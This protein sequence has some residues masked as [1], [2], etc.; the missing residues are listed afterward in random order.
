V[1]MVMV[2]REVSRIGVNVELVNP[3]LGNVSDSRLIQKEESVY[4]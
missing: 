3:D 1:T 4:D 2:S